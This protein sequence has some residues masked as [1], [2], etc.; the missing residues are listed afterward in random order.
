MKLPMGND[1]DILMNLQDAGCDDK[2]IK[3]YFQ[4][5]EMGRRT[6]QIRLLSLHRA[7]LLDEIHEE[8]QKLDCLDYLIYAMKEAEKG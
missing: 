1:E 3:K 5:Q 7:S 2:I 6:E 8:Q 4:L